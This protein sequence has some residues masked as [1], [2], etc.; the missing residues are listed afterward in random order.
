MAE[1]WEA[2]RPPQFEDGGPAIFVRNTFLDIEVP[3]PIQLKKSK[4][5]PVPASNPMH[6]ESSSD[7]EA[8]PQEVDDECPPD[9][10][11]S[12]DSGRPRVPS[13]PALHRLVTQD[14]WECSAY[15][16]TERWGKREDA[17]QMAVPMVALQGAG[18]A[19]SAPSIAQPGPYAAPIPMPM[20]MAMGGQPVV[21][22]VVQQRQSLMLPGGFVMVPMMPMHLVGQQMQPCQVQGLPASSGGASSAAGHAGA[23][24]PQEHPPQEPAQLDV[25]PGPERP[26]ALSVSSAAAA[27]QSHVLTRAFSVDSTVYRIHWT[28]DA[29]KLRGTD[30]SAVSPAFELA[31]GEQFL[32]VLF[33][34]M[35]YPVHVSH[36]RGGTSFKKADG[37]GYVQL[38]CESQLPESLTPVTFRITTG[39]G[40]KTA[41]SRGPV[42]HDF[43]QSA[44]AGLPKE[45]E[46]WDFNAVVDEESSTFVVCLEIVPN[47]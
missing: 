25:Q 30:K 37:K 14:A 28:I 35:V 3:R 44:V 33:R 41:P 17:P 39:S 29:R 7:D 16:D 2:P 27:P 22:P 32:H 12:A 40:E 47:T 23:P 5:V 11:A 34:M 36:A 4:T 24:V 21:V 1:D 8:D 31:L 9:A 20:P 42:L 10:Q 19:A 43:S 26:A 38:K 46:E 6:E 15:W 18:A 45:I 13:R